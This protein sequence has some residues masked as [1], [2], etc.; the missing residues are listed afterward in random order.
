M[1]KLPINLSQKVILVSNEDDTYH[2]IYYLHYN[3]TGSFI[4][5]FV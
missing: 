2:A 5:N 4:D 3:L 1:C